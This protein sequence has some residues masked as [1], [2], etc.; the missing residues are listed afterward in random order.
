[1]ANCKS[2]QNLS[3]PETWQIFGKIAHLIQSDETTFDIIISII[4]EAEK[5]GKLDDVKIMPHKI[6]ENS[7]DK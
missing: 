4:L 1:M 6:N 2:F 3:L 5:E 7:Y